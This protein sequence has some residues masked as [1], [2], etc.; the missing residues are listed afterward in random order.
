MLASTV[1]QT[2]LIVDGDWRPSSNG[3]MI[4][5]RSPADPD[6]VVGYAAA[7]SKEDAAAAIR[8]A[9]AAF[10]AWAA[11]TYQERAHYLRN[12]AASLQSDV[13]DRIRLFVREHGKILAEAT[14]EMTR[15][16]GRF[17]YTASL[18]DQV[19]ADERYPAPPFRTVVTK[20]PRGVAA[21]IIPWNWPLSILGAKLPQA[22]LAGNSVVIKPS[23]SSP[24]AT[25]QTIK[26]MA[27]AL[28]KGVI[29]VVTGAPD[30]VGAEL[31]ANPLVRKV[32]FTGSVAAGKMVMAAAANT[33]KR[34]TLELGGNDAGIVL[35]DAELSE[36]T[37]A[38]MVA[39]SFMTAG[40]MCM[41]LKRLYVHESIYPRLL[42][43]MAAALSRYVVGN[44]LD[45]HTSMGPLNNRPQHEWIQELV[46]EARQSGATV[47][48]FGSKRDDREFDHGYFHLPSLV[49][50]VDPSCKVVA[51]EQFGP[52]LP[53]I[54]FRTEEEAIRMA[55]DSEFG[56]CSS[57]WSA[58]VERATALARRLEAG[59]TYIN[60]HGPLGQDNR[61]P[62]GGMKQSGIG[63]QLGLP[64]VLEFLEYHSISAP[65]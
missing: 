62:F 49:T 42:E 32:S 11:L 40:Q 28:P 10:P 59:Y 1:V 57:V 16:G 24:L 23:S 8:A 9:D 58:D 14:M 33:L 54:P 21:L 39:G 36:G 51:C 19:A 12:L 56:L 46:A 25:V 26:L 18:A 63:R 43:A 61:A 53:V 31:L 30:E 13:Q 65:A 22:L 38:K 34:L 6:E 45:P 3:R 47:L 4:E 37:I 44:G 15:L 52:V 41:A 64:G 55:N 35:E 60:S 29:N 17:E 20:Q 5:V 50:N 2:E 48:E 7:G 27:D